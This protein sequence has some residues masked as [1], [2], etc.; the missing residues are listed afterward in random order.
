[1]SETKILLEESEIPTQWYNVVAD[2]PNPP[3]PPL[4]AD[5]EP[6]GPDA[7]TA[8]FPDALI[9]QEVSA[10]RWID[11]PEAVRE[12]YT[13]WRP[14]PLYRAHRL[15][16]AL[17]TPA[18]IYYKYEGVSPAG[19]HKPNTAVA[20]AYYNQQAGVRRLTTETGAGQWG[21]SLALAGQMFDI[22]VRVYMVRVSYEQKPFRRSMMHSWGAEVLASP[23]ELKITTIP[24]RPS[25]RLFTTCRRSARSELRSCIQAEG[26]PSLGACRGR[27]AAPARRCMQ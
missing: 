22:E 26:A 24:Q 2:M 1:M 16:K 10:E 19:S 15:E 21:S 27:K 7:L 9:E 5:G 3:V 8:I 6:I 11:I 20:R 14:S 18:R 12:I 25:T 13:L 23:T 17:G 4:G